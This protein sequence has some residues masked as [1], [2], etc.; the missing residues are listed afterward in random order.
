MERSC[1][2]EGNYRYLLRIPVSNGTK[3]V[4]FVMC[5]PSTADALKDDTTTRNLQKWARQNSVGQVV[6]VNLYAYRA[7]QHAGLSALSEADAV[8]EKNMDAISRTAV[9]CDEVIVACA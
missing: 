5:N 8:G 7:S 3:S 9:E 2:R 1:E 6:I 4:L